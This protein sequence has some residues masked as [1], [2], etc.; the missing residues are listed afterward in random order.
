MKCSFCERPLTCK[1]CGQDF[2]PRSATAHL[3]TYQPDMAVM[4]PA[5]K[6]VLACKWCGFVYGGPDEEPA[7]EA[8]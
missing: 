7:D 3:A 5:C 6:A 4:C 2:R 1:A 8:G